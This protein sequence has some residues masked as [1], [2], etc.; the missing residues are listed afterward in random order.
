MTF[1]TLKKYAKKGRLSHKIIAEFSGMIDGK[2]WYNDPKWVSGTTLGNLEYFKTTKNQLSA[3]PSGNI[4]L[5]NCCFK[6]EFRI[7]DKQNEEDPMGEAKCN[8]YDSEGVVA[9]Y[10]G[11]GW[12]R[13]CK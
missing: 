2:E 4:E 10:A 5:S 3:L 7:S 12:G 9:A 11:R 13:C 8:K 1:A 6:I